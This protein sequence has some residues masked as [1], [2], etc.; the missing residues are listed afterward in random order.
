MEEDTIELIDHL[1]LIWKRKILVIVVT[2]VCIG[3][4]VG[5]GAINS[6]YKTSPP[7]TYGAEVYVKIGKRVRLASSISAT[8]NYIEEP[9]NLVNIIPLRYLPKIKNS[10]RYHLNVLQIGE[11]AMLRLNLEGP[12]KGVEMGLKELVDMLIEEHRIKA[13]GSVVAYN[14]L[15]KNLKIDSE[16]L[17]EE[18]VVM[19]A[20][21]RDMKEREKKYL[22][23]ADSVKGEVLLGSDRSA[24]LN[25]L[26]LK[27]IDKEKEVTL[28]RAKLREL[29]SQLLMHKITLG[30]LEEYKTETFGEIKSTAKIPKVRNRTKDII[31]AAGV[32]GLILALFIVF[33]VEYIEESKLR[34]KGKLQG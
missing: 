25:M 22:E 19:I 9:G 17:K 24:F 34:R 5:V 31:I 3:V 32:A 15:V 1:S 13:E 33:F 14:N 6:R 28:S 18:I 11:L 8:I 12:D 20:G 26:Y 30:N 23:M 10:S 16:K 2:L 21:V 27:T 29:Q 7:V 4:G